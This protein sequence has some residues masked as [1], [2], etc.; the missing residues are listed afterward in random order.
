[1]KEE[2]F[3]YSLLLIVRKK[4]DKGLL[5]RIIWCLL[6]TELNKRLLMIVCIPYSG[7]HS[8]GGQRLTGERMIRPA[9]EWKSV[10][11]VFI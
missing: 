5:S 8:R 4:R 10:F 2:F 9:G 1:M 3:G 6:F 11:H 7:I